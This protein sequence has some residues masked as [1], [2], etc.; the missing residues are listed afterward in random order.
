VYC[1]LRYFCPPVFDLCFTT[2]NTISANHGGG[3]LWPI[4]SPVARWRPSRV[5]R[6]HPHTMGDDAYARLCVI[7]SGAR[8]VSHPPPTT[9]LSLLFSRCRRRR[10]S[11][12]IV[13]I[14]CFSSFNDIDMSH[15]ML[16]DCC[17]LCCQESGPI[18]AV[19]GQRP[20]WGR[21][22]SSHRRR[23]RDVQ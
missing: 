11:I 22:L 19:W 2:H 10:D 21:R 17:M 14:I 5:R 7:S 8:A 12:L 15:I 4:P 13:I 18:A 6:Y 1:T 9:H 16:V 3:R 23:R 20:P